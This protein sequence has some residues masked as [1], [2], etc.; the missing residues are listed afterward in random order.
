MSST[1]LKQLMARH[2]RVAALASASLGLSACVATTTPESSSSAMES[3]SSVVESSSSVVSSSSSSAMQSSS[4]LAASS[5]SQ[6]QALGEII[7]R[8]SC[9]SA[10][11][12]S[13]PIDLANVGPYDLEISKD[14]Y[15]TMLEDK[16]TF[17]GSRG[18][19][20]WHMYTPDQAMASP[21]EK[22]PLI[23]SLH[24]GYGRE[25]DDHHILQDG[26]PYMLGSS[27]G[28]LTTENKAKYPTYIIFPHCR[29][30][31]AREDPNNPGV[32]LPEER[33]CPFYSNEWSSSG[34]AKFQ[35]QNQPS[36]NGQTLIELI[37]HTVKTYNIDPARIYVT[38]VSMGG[39]GTWELAQRRPDLVA[40]AIPLAGHT[41]ADQYLNAFNT[42]LVPVWAHAGEKDNTNSYNDTVQAV[43]K[44]D[45]D[46]GCA[47]VTGYDGYQR[48]DQYS[49]SAHGHSLWQRVYLNPDLWSWLFAQ[50]QPRSNSV[51]VSSSS[52]V[53]GASSSAPATGQG[54]DGAEYCS[55]FDGSNAV[56]SELKPSTGNVSVVDGLDGK[57]LA[58]QSTSYAGSWIEAPKTP[59]M[60]KGYVKFDAS[61][62]GSGGGWWFLLVEHD[63]GSSASPS[64][65]SGSRMRVEPFDG[66]N[67]LTWNRLS[68]GDTVSPNIYD[69]NQRSSS[70]TLNFG[71]WACYELHFDESQDLLEVSINGSV[72]DGLTLDNDA[73]TGNDQR[74]QGAHGD[75]F[76]MNVNAVRIG[77]GGQSRGTITIDNLVVSQSPIGCN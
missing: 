43:N 40:A 46:G 20:P 58:I 48:G 18:S 70:G 47:W 1:T 3:S 7:P 32:M 73:S 23:V 28:L 74:W 72:I 19:L 37:E 36:Q 62:S 27:N 34:G 41:P 71:Q 10:P 12:A 22:Y 54:C 33:K 63:G 52:S 35:V 17:D 45:G 21:N 5:S 68:A 39:G 29:E 15:V 53:G 66:S 49:M 11:P 4:S 51:A 57:G 67:W 60:T 30:L 6:P 2:W 31:P 65:D 25:G 77:Y 56:P 38:G 55:D 13:K 59:E 16:G 14:E 24:G 75:N 8:T 44:I 26:A 61:L 69:P 64:V 76:D 50:A 9:P 42:S